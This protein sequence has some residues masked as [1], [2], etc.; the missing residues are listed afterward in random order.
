MREL[1]DRRA[2]MPTDVQSQN[3]EIPHALEAIVQRCLMFDPEKRYLDSQALADDLERFL[4]RR[5]LSHAV[6]PSRRERVENWVSR[7]HRSM[8]GFGVTIVLGMLLGYFISPTTKELT[9]APRGP[10][11]THAEFQLAVRYL[12]GEQHED[13]VDRLRELAQ[14]YPDHPVRNVLLGVALAGSRLH[15]EE[16]DAQAAFREGISA[17]DAESILRDWARANPAVGKNFLDFANFLFGHLRQ[18][19]SNRLSAKNSSPQS[20]EDQADA[21]SKREH[22]EV[23]YQALSLALELDPTSEKAADQ[24]ARVEEFLGKFESAYERVTRLIE[25][26]QERL[27]DAE[28]INRITHRGR[29][30]LLWAAQ[31]CRVHDLGGQERALRLLRQNAEWLQSC[32]KLAVQ[33]ARNDSDPEKHAR[34]VYHYFWITAETWLALGEAENAQQ[35]AANAA[36]AFPNAKRALDYLS[37]HALRRAIALPP[38]QFADLRERLR[39]GLRDTKVSQNQPN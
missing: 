22:Y 35:L 30:A 11:E 2:I 7:N 36:R 32:E 37:A 25:T 13:A 4:S 27:A 1:L 18:Y 29:V 16:T 20:P 17:P 23:L 12:L 6:N 9:Q 33:I 10:I 34:I 31:L 39:E 15:L 38:A 28:M 14:E 5:P 24:L 21:R 26:P 19:E 3:P 8:V